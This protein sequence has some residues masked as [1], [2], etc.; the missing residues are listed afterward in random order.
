MKDK[1]EINFYN[2][3]HLGDHVFNIHFLN[4]Y[5][6]YNIIFNYYVHSKYFNELNN[7]IKN[8]NIHLYALEN[9]SKV[10]ADIYNLWIGHD[11]FYYKEISKHNNMYDLFYVEYFN[12]ISLKFNLDVFIKNNFD[13]L[14]DNINTKY[15]IQ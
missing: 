10:P 2:P 14:F 13:L 8:K 15:V 3:F 1:R 7:F 12:R 9:T 6:N 11:D 5:K 4:K